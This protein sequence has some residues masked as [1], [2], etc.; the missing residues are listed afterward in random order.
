MPQVASFSCCSSSVA[1]AAAADGWRWISKRQCILNE[2]PSDSQS[3][4]TNEEMEGTLTDCSKTTEE[5]QEEAVK[6][7]CCSRDFMCVMRVHALCP[8]PVKAE[9]H[10]DWSITAEPTSH[11][12]HWEI[13]MDVL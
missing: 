11:L 1:A 6:N 8:S 13:S 12:T 3:S 9:H 2:F 10:R 4:L 5:E 7:G